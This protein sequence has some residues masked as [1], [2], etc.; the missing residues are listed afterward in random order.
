MRICVLDDVYDCPAWE[1]PPDDWRVDPTPFLK[2]HDFD[3]VGLTKD[4]AVGKL[5]ELSRNGFD[6]FFNLLAGAWDEE[7]PGIEVVQ[8]LERLNVPFTGATSEF[9]E[10]SREAMKQVCAA[11][12]IGYPPFVLARTGEDIERALDT[13]RFPLIVKHPSSYSSIDLTRNSRVQTPFG[14]RLQARRI[15]AKYGAALIEEFIEGREFTVLVAEDPDDLARPVTYCPIEFTFPPGESFKHSDMKWKDF[16]D[17]REYPVKDL[18]L[19]EQLRKVS[20]D[21]FLGIRGASFGRCDL[22]MRGDGALFMLEINPNCGVYYAPSEPGSADLA[23]L[24]DPSGHQGF[25]DLLIRSALARHDRRQRGWE[26]RSTPGSGFA[27]FAL[28][29]IGKGERIVT[30]E[31]APHTLVTRS[32]V[33]TH[34]NDREREWFRR[35]AWP[36]TDEVWVTWSHD[37]EEWMPINHSCDPNAWLEGL[38]LVARRPIAQGEEIHVDYATYGNNILAPFDCACGSAECRGRVR[39]NDHLQP[40]IARYGPHVS[41]FVR[42]KRLEA[43]SEE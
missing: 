29:S 10:P 40:F 34:W 17:M 26:V 19:E 35:Y 31:G 33:A 13:L 27:V 15:M 18:A 23:L 5:T 43:G 25:T 2:D 20:A 16:H 12:D 28:R 11:W 32:H 36:L 14:L 30:F 21:F 22:R 38:D 7:S 24:H 8:T 39:E 6:L 37:P 42:A 3:V 9:Y 1:A 4:V 41:D